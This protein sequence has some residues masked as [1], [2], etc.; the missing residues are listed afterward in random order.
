MDKIGRYQLVKKVGHAAMG[1]VYK[2]VDPSIREPERPAP[3]V[4]AS[5]HAFLLILRRLTLHVPLNIM[6]RQ[7]L[8][9]M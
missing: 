1:V 9:P 2:A 5:W 7:T 6:Q 8:Y 3:D 4:L